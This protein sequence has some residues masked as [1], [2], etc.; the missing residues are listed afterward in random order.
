[1]TAVP[2]PPIIALG[3]FRKMKHSYKGYEIETSS[4]N[5]GV[6]EATAKI[7]PVAGYIT[8]LTLM[9]F[10]TNAAEAE[11]SVLKQ[12]EILIDNALAARR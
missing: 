1:L 2:W 11:Q 9:G 8:T 6:I 7:T 5:D 3:D 10:P 12:A 4:S